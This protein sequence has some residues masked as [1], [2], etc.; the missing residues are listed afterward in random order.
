MNG[1]N[2]TT[3]TKSEYRCSAQASYFLLLTEATLWLVACPNTGASVGLTPARNA[4]TE[5]YV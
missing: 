1:K 2:L 5:Y 3:V 4:A